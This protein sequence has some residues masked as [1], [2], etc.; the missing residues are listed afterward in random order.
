M[1]GFS[2]LD[3]TGGQQL[4]TGGGEWNI[5]LIPLEDIIPAKN[6]NYRICDVEALAE[7][8]QADGLLSP[9]NVR[10]IEDSGKYE[11]ISGERRYTAMKLLNSKGV[12]GYAAAPCKVEVS[13]SDLQAEIR[14]I[15]AN[16]TTRILTDQEK[17]RQAARLAELIDHLKGSGVKVPGRKREFVADAL[18]TSTAQVGRMESVDKNLIP[19]AKAEFEAGAL[20]FSTAYETSLLPPEQ[21]AEVVENL[22]SGE[23]VDIKSVK[24]R[25]RASAA[26]ASAPPVMP[27]Y[28]P[29]APVDAPAANEEHTT[30]TEAPTLKP[31]PFCGSGTMVITECRELEECSNFECCEN[32]GYYCIACNMNAGGCGAS[33]GYRGSKED[34]IRAWNRRYGAGG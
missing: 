34:A 15:R 4:D 27:Q 18:G 33:S 31:C 13:L 14:L 24:E 10:L 16:S 11:L 7:S 29:G 12:E 9:L 17:V 2:L 8:I 25:R 19:E 6:N 20:N 30:P 22:K 26:P 23:R 32:N 28:A 5:Q 3:L 1:K 21:Q